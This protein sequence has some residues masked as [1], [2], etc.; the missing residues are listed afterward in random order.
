MALGDVNGDGY[1]DLVAGAELASNG[2][3]YVFRGSPTGLTATPSQTIDAPSGSEPNFGRA[4][5]VADFNLDGRSDVAVGTANSASAGSIYIYYGSAGGLVIS[6]APT[7]IVVEYVQALTAVDLN[8]DGYPDLLS[9]SA[10][11]PMGRGLIRVFQGGEAGVLR[12]VRPAL[13][14]GSGLEDRFGSKLVGIGD[15]DGDGLGDVAIG[16][17]TDGS[18]RAGRIQIHRGTSSLSE[19]SILTT[20]HATWSGQANDYYLLQI[21]SGDFNGDRYGDVLA[22]EAGNGATA[23]AG[24]A[25]VFLGG[26]LLPSTR[27]MA[28]RAWTAPDG[29]HFGIYIGTLDANGDGFCDAVVNAPDAQTNGMTYVYHGS[30]LGFG[31]TP[32]STLIGSASSQYRGMIAALGSHPSCRPTSFGA[33][34]VADP[35]V[36]RDRFVSA[37][38]GGSS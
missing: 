3:V 32:S 19:A 16:A 7:P 29:G 8:G 15:V 2:V 20:P 33:V 17:G 26:P 22:G 38:P 23:I 28:S 30:A 6:P 11:T 35:L 5:A 10:D 24:T 4:L 13:L 12:T 9:G 27:A 37:W 18:G 21:A 25:Y 31:T 36:P 1:A 34:C 14:T